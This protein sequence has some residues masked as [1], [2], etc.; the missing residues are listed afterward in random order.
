[1]TAYW[2]HFPHQADVGIEGIGPTR[3]A[4]LEQAALALTAVV[5]APTDVEPHTAVD[6]QCEATADD[7]LLV[8]WLNALVFEMATRNMVFGRFEVTIDGH[9]LHGRLWGETV[10]RERHQPV[11]EVKGAT[12]TA[13]RMAVESDGLWHAACVVDI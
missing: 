1:V 13:L 8:D 3:A 2:R 4:A 5:T 10:D 7:L 9:R 12:Y 6:V 11:V